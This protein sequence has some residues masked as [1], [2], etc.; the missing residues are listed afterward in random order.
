MEPPSQPDWKARLGQLSPEQRALLQQRLGKKA[1]AAASPQVPRRPTGGP[2]PLSFSQQRLWFLDQLLPRAAA[3]NVPYAMELSG[4]LN[5]PALA[6]ALEAVVNRH[7]VLRTVFRAARTTPV[8]VVLRNWPPVLR[9]VDLRQ[10]PDSRTPAAV[11]AALREEATRPFQLDRDLTLRCLLLQLADDLSIFLHVSHHVAWD[12]RSR[13]VL[14]EDLGRAYATACKGEPVSL[15]ELPIQYADYAAWQRERLQGAE[16]EQLAA[17]WKGQL[18]SAPPAL[19]LP[20]DHPR[21]PVQSLKGGKYFFHLPQELVEAAK[22]VARQEGVTLY[23]ALLAA[24]KTFLFWLTGQE[25]ISVGAPIAGRNLEQTEPL[26]GF[27]INTLVL[28]T[29]VAGDL[30]FR[31]LLRCVREVTLGA[32]AHQDMPFEKL[33]EVLRP[34]RDLSRNP[35]FQVNFRV[36]SASPPA[37]TLPGVTIAPLEVI[38]TETSKFDLA[39]ELGAAAGCSSYW[40]YST[41]LFELPTI[42]ALSQDFERLLAGLLQAPDLPIGDLPEG[43]PLAQRRPPAPQRTE[44]VLGL[45]RRKVIQPIPPRRDDPPACDPE[46]TDG[47]PLS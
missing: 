20:V 38:D 11:A 42:V 45:A 16:L 2:C 17:Y 40:E 30:S 18:A 7:E 5:V 31:Q 32:Y 3:Y 46:K 1:P 37:L 43:Q 13:V 9:T 28:H 24:F 33:V 6:A 41:D 14:Y 23:M 8:Q 10:A 47:N 39:L 19:E 22:G 29:K 27:F 26:I 36:A 21:P 12:Y 15:P 35:I 34:P 4:E 25:G 44:P